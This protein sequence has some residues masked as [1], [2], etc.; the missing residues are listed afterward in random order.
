MAESITLSCPACGNTLD[1]AEDVSL[2]VCARCG[3]EYVVRRGGGIVSLAPAAESGAHATN[4]AEQAVVDA[5]IAQLKAEIGEIRNALWEE[6]EGIPQESLYNFF[7]MLDDILHE[8]RGTERQRSFLTLFT[9]TESR[10]EDIKRVLYSLTIEDLDA[11]IRHCSELTSK[12]IPMEHY[13]IRFKRL[14]RLEQQLAAQ[15]R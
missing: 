6:K 1:I 7:V 13:E 15:S 14:K 10:E 4:D 8:R 11:L 3:N 2:F 9:R 5:H 12:N